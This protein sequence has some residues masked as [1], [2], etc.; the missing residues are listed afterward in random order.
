MGDNE[1]FKI[2]LQKGYKDNFEGIK[3]KAAEKAKFAKGHS[4]LFPYYKPEVKLL[5]RYKLI[6]AF[7][8][9]ITK[10]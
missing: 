1:F 7:R 5:R 2:N 8:S 6:Y 3:K 4:F 10:V 9:P